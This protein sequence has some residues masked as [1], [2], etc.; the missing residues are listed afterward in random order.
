MYRRTRVCAACIGVAVLTVA[1]L[2]AD[3]GD[4]VIRLQHQGLERT[5][6]LHQPAR[7]ATPAPLVLALHGRGQNTKQLRD[8]LKLDAVADREGVAVLYPDAVDLIWSYGRPINPPGPM[9]GSDPVDDIGFIRRLLDDLVSRKIADARRVYVVGSS[10]GGLMTFT[11]ACTLDDRIAAAAALITGMTDHQRD[12][13]R[14]ARPVPMLALAGTNDRT[15]G[16]DGWLL[17][18]GRLLSVPETMEFW[19]TLHGCAQQDARLLPHRD[20]T[21]RTRILLVEWSECKSAARLRLYRVEG[22]GH[23]LP[24]LEP[25]EPTPPTKWGLRNSDIDTAEEVWAYFKDYVR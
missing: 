2:H 6:V 21:E 14:P 22:G 15:Q 1:S 11:L 4:E 7:T 24:S 8:A 13:C 16:Y 18:A 3:E 9:V 19:R 5:A 23:Q 17:A 25:I 12:E 10:R 20:I